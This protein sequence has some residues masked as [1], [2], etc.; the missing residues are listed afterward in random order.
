VAEVGRGLNGLLRILEGWKPPRGRTGGRS[1]HTP[2]R[3][4][5]R[6]RLWQRRKSAPSPA[7]GGG[8]G[9]GASAKRAGGVDIL[10]PPA[11]LRAIAEAQLRRSYQR[12]AAEGGLCSPASGRGGANP[13]AVQFNQ[14]PSLSAAE[15]N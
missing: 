8:W 12:T 7:C 10:P 15:N 5:I 2:E 3:D 6:S 14:R 11:A 1:P 4:E 13:L 9:G